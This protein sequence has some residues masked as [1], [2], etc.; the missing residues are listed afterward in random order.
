MTRRARGASPP[1]AGPA[2]PPRSQSARPSPV[3]A[4]DAETFFDL[5]LD[6][7]CIAGVDGCFRKVNPAFERILGW[8]HEEILAQA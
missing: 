1:P 3:T 6:M 8:T 4:Y 2:A 5:S 7:L